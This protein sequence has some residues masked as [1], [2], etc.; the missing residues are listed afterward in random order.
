[1]TGASVFC[2]EKTRSPPVKVL[3]SQLRDGKDCHTPSGRSEYVIRRLGAG[4][5]SSLQV[6]MVWMQGT[7]VEV[8]PDHNTVLILDETGNFLVSGI[9]SVPRGKPCLSPGKYVMVMGVI[10]SHNPEPVLRAVKMADLSENALIHRKNWIY[11]VEDLQ[12]ILP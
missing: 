1:M 8:Q 2:A 5:Q 7:V 11:E 10:Q 3:S 12:Q 9:N 6:S 4:E